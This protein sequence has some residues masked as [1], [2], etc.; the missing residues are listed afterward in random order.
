M[1]MGLFRS[2][3]C[4]ASAY[5]QQV[6]PYGCAQ[7]SALPT[8]RVAGCR[9]PHAATV[10]DV[11]ND[12][13]PR[14]PVERVDPRDEPISRIPR[15]PIMELNA[16]TKLLLPGDL[17][18]YELHSTGFH[19]PPLLSGKAANVPVAAPDPAR[20]TLAAMPLSVRTCL[21]PK[22]EEDAPEKARHPRAPLSRFGPERMR[23]W[24]SILI[25]G[26]MFISGFGFGGS[27]AV[28]RD[29]RQYPP[30]I[31]PRQTP[32]PRED[33]AWASGEREHRAW[34]VN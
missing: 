1:M 11:T 15:I 13:H 25:Q 6:R 23:V 14:D 24:S 22:R 3:V 18:R 20:N 10:A 31:L 34:I 21:R 29:R 26:E 5:S 16:A 2:T 4:G 9:F 7:A 32:K 8:D 27:K 33:S 19:Q 17:Q 30:R 12:G 28:R